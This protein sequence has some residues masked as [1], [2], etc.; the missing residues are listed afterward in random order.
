MEGRTKAWRDGRREGQSEKIKR[1][2]LTDAKA[3][4][5]RQSERRKDV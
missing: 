4:L 1:Y 2:E 5:E 3:E